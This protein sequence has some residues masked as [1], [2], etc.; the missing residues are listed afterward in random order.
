MIK[1][2]IKVISPLVIVLLSFLC[3][4]CTNATAE[5]DEILNEIKVKYVEEYLSEDY[6]EATVDDVYI[7]KFYGKYGDAYVVLVTDSYDDHFTAVTQETICGLVFSYS[8]SNSAKVLYDSKF[9]TLKEA[10]TNSIL[11]IDDL[12][13]LNQFF[14]QGLCEGFEINGKAI[15]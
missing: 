6:P 4:S 8:N 14:P 3:V 5:S 15:D 1:R 12:K 9:Y 7:E 10:Y 13:N 11:S 2:I